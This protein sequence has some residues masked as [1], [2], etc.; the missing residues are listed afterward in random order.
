MSAVIAVF[1]G[2]F[3][4]DDEPG[5][6][7]FTDVTGK[8]PST[9]EN[10]ATITVSDINVASPITVSGGKYNING[11]A[12]TSDAG[13]V[14]DGD[15]V[16]AQIT[17]GSGFSTTYTSTVTI[18]GVSDAFSATTRGAVSTV[19]ANGAGSVIGNM[20]ANS[21]LASIFDGSA[22]GGSATGGKS[23]ATYPGLGTAGKNWGGVAK[24][25]SRWMTWGPN[26]QAYSLGTG[27][28]YTTTLYLEG[29]NNGSSWTVMDSV[30]FTD[31]VAAISI[32]RSLSYS[33]TTY[34]SHRVRAITS[35]ASSIVNMGFI[36]LRFYEWT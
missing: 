31:T 5:A 10:S 6:F 15:T 3:S 11:G 26:D 30:A 18:G 34:T 9:A 1:A 17:T 16:S 29:S 24:S 28:G 4:P 32:D 36:E 19:I 14:S 13:T 2:G 35:Y 25:I 22:T 20:T 27:A 21:G 12:Y 23:P 8:N 33:A 7:T